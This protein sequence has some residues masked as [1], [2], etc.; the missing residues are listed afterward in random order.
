MD[1]K[2]VWS[3]R[4]EKS[5]ARILTYLRDTVSEDFANVDLLHL[6]GRLI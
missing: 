3:A 2:V 1:E 6:C 4:A 5:M